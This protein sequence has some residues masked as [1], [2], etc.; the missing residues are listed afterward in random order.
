MFRT[1]EDSHMQMESTL[2]S[3]STKVGKRRLEAATVEFRAL[4]DSEESLPSLDTVF[5]SFSGKARAFRQDSSAGTSFA[6]GYHQ[7]GLGS[8]DMD[9]NSEADG[10]RSSAESPNLQDKTV[11]LV[12]AGVAHKQVL[13]ESGLSSPL[14]IDRDDEDGRGHDVRSGFTASIG[15]LVNTVVGCELGAFGF[16]EFTLASLD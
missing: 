15:H 3:P 13:E 11:S 12:E 14:R 5:N 16:G 6:A 9:T 7:S 2:L 10:P 1:G 8:L 4:S